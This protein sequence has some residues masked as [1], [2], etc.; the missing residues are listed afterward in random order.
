MELIRVQDADSRKL[1]ELYMTFPENENGY[2]NN[3]YGYTYEQFLGWVEMKRNWTLGKDLPEGYVPD[4][5]YVLAVED[6]YVGVF[7]FR[8]YLNDFLREGA[9]HIGYIISPAYR[10][11]GYATKGL[12]M[13][14]GI[15]KRQ[16]L[17]GETEAYLSVNKDNPASLKVQQ[18][19]GAYI[20]HENENEYFTR[21]PVFESAQ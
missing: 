14:L 1:Y 10:G 7:N 18:N 9:G 12:G 4:T 16:G 3:V 5:S 8:H 17:R 20:H 2:M 21:I 19:N 6:V 11:K 13:V 15:V